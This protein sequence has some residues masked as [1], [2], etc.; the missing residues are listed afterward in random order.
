MPDNYE[1]ARCPGWGGGCT[2][3]IAFGDL[4]LCKDCERSKLRALVKKLRVLMKDCEGAIPGMDQHGQTLREART[5]R[6]MR[7]LIGKETG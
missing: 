7:D 6:R 1:R 3:L 2:E 4:G 5:Y